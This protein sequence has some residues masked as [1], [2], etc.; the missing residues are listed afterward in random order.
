MLLSMFILYSCGISLPA[1]E[2]ELSVK[3]LKKPVKYNAPTI[4]TISITT[5]TIWLAFAL[6][7]VLF[8]GDGTCAN[9]NFFTPNARQEGNH[10]KLM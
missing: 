5:G 3:S 10:K 4:D 7:F 2:R 8:D 9:L 1:S 6:F